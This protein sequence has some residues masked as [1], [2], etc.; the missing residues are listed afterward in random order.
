MRAKT[1][2]LGEVEDSVSPGSSS[3]SRPPKALSRAKSHVDV[4]HQPGI[5]RDGRAEA[6]LAVPADPAVPEPKVE[7]LA[8]PA[9]E[10]KVEQ[11]LPKISKSVPPADE[12]EDGLADAP[13]ISRE[14]QREFKEFKDIPIKAKAKAKSKF[15]SMKRPASSKAYKSKKPAPEA[16]AGA[17]DG[18]S[19]GGLHA[20][21]HYSPPSS[22]AEPRAL[23][24]AFNEVASPTSSDADGKSSPVVPPKR[25]NAAAKADGPSKKA[26]VDG[27]AEPSVPHCKRPKKSEGG[28]ASSSK[29]GADAR[30][31]EKAGDGNADAGGGR[32]SMGKKTTF[33]GRAPPRREVCRLRFDVMVSTFAEKISPWVHSP[34]QVEAGRVEQIALFPLRCCKP[35]CLLQGKVF[36]FRGHCPI[37]LFVYLFSIMLA[38]IPTSYCW[39]PQASLPL[40][41]PADLVVELGFP[42]PLECAHPVKP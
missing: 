26:K 25:K 11:P 5:S 39:W 16:D 38:T 15:K 17:T 32:G 8:V 33:A 23:D 1:L 18:E 14:H 27:V 30:K 29:S 12:C 31:C 4:Q 36:V 7:Q 34:S 28:E 40:T 6:S 24:S 19:E 3:D 2:E 13:M 42:E 20:T 21:Q 9:P 10:P 35:C 37:Q 41:N 22:P